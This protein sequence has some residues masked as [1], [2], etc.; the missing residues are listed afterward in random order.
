MGQQAER[1]VCNKNGDNRPPGMIQRG[2]GIEHA[3]QVCVLLGEAV[4]NAQQAGSFAVHSK[5]DQKQDNDHCRN[6][7]HHEALHPIR[8]NVGMCAAEHDVNQQHGGGDEQRPQGR[9]A[10]HDLEH[11]QPGYQLP[12]Q[13]EKQHQ[14]KDR[15]EYP[16]TLGLIAVAE[17]FRD[18][19]VAEPMAR[20]GNQA[21]GDQHADIHPGRIQEAAPDCRQPPLVAQSRTAEKSGTAGRGRGKGKRQKEGSVRAA[22]GGKVVSVFDPPLG[23]HADGQHAADI[24]QEKNPR[25]GNE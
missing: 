12:G 13:I 23:K 8:Q 16:N 7:Q 9:H 20:S 24:Q 19:T 5:S 15:D 18:G 21:H 17:I 10:Q 25:P 14:G 1:D 3:D 11:H 6:Q 2:L 4:D 22:R